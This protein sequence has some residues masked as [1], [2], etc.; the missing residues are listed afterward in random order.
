MNR[1]QLLLKGQNPNIR[2][3]Q[4][5]KEEDCE[6]VIVGETKDNPMTIRVSYNIFKL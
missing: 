2:K 6:L 3:M 1:R 5:T 4:K